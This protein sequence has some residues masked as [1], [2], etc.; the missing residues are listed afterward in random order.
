MA[1]KKKV[2]GKG[3]P[4]QKDYPVI[5][6]LELPKYSNEVLASDEY[7]LKKFKSPKINGA[8]S[9]SEFTKKSPTPTLSSFAKRRFFNKRVSET[10]SIPRDDYEIKRKSLYNTQESNETYE[11]YIK[12]LSAKL[13]KYK[14]KTFAM[15]EE[16]KEIETRFKSEENSMKDEIEKL[17]LEIKKNKS[18]YY[19]H[20]TIL[21]EEILKLRRENEENKILYKMHMNQIAEIVESSSDS[22]VKN[23]VEAILNEIE[24]KFEES[25]NEP[26]DSALPSNHTAS[27]KDMLEH[28]HSSREQ[29]KPSQVQAIVLY[30]YSPSSHGELKLKSGD[31][32]TILNADE[33]NGWWLGRIGEKIGMFPRNCVML[34]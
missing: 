17:N 21:N 1:D 4:K 6:K 24:S 11:L 12:N 8:Q 15:E 22:D 18:E 14:K 23:K 32:I 27:F 30:N 34:D 9:S 26:D 3:K 25:S 19:D 13:D 31:R 16:I 10:P 20:Q 5:K 33:N 2:L 7:S 28:L 29:I